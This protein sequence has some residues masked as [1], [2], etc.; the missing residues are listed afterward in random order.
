MSEKGGYP[1][2]TIVYHQRSEWIKIVLRSI[3]DCA[4]CVR[5]FEYKFIAE[6]APK[7]WRSQLSYDHPI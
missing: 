4:F 6:F 7:H 5:G 1:I 3:G 2:T